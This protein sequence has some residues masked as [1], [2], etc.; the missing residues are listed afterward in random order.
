[1]EFPKKI[2]PID[3]PD[4]KKEWEI[5]GYCVEHVLNGNGKIVRVRDTQGL[6]AGEKPFYGMPDLVAMYWFHEGAWWW[7]RDP[8]TEEIDAIAERLKA[9]GD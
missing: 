7:Q 4:R 3:L 2:E 5:A 9:R 8:L 1:M 6:Y